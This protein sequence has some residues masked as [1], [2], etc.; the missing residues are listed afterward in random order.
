MILR[1]QIPKDQLL[2]EAEVEMVAKR[3]NKTNTKERQGDTRE[4]SSTTFLFPLIFF[5]RKATWQKSKHH[6][7]GGH[8]EIMSCIKGQ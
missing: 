7:L 8:L 6:L 5:T 4:K 1:A 2:F 3:N